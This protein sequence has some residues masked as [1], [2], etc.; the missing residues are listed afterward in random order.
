MVIDKKL[1][2]LSSLLI[3]LVMLFSICCSCKGDVADDSSATQSAVSSETTSIDDSDETESELESE[4]SSS[5]ESAVTSSNIVIDSV[6]R[7][8]IKPVS[9]TVSLYDP[10]SGIYGFNWNSEKKPQEPVVQVCEGKVFD[11]SKCKE[12]PVTVTSFSVTRTANTKAE[13]YYISKAQV[14]LKA[15][16]D[17]TYRAYDKY[18]K[19]GSEPAVFKTGNPKASS[20]TFVHI[21]DTQIATGENDTMHY[22][23][24][25]GKDFEKVLQGIKKSVS[26]AAFL[27][28]TGDIVQYSYES[29]WD[30]MI[31]NNFKLLSN[32]PIMPAA[33]NHDS[34][35][36]RGKDA[37]VKHFNINAPKQDTEKGIFYYFDYGDVRFITLNT[38]LI[39]ATG[40]LE[41]TQINWL[42]RVLE[43]NTKKWTIVSMHNPMFSVGK[44]VQHDESNEKSLAIR[45]QLYKIFAR[46]NVD[47]VLQGHD[48]TY[49]KTY[50]VL[51]DGTIDNNPDYE[52]VGSV[53]YTVNPKGV[54]YAVHGTSGN[55]SRKP[56]GDPDKNVYE[57][58]GESHD[59]SWANITVENN[60]LTVKIM[61]LEN[62]Q[63]KLWDSYGILKK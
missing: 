38:N 29:Y 30:N 57:I 21:S 54:I 11:E 42:K 60:K 55:Q 28:H 37:I 63:P 44:Y 50:P 5:A 16:T 39:S 62:G 52:M 24:G 9:L 61:Y 53:K 23:A 36:Y 17:Y 25:T 12:Y 10:E 22:A 51:Q 31:N 13:Y 41:Q 40:K 33:G 47:L 34:P 45:A 4:L 8:R 18:A 48:H 32:L 6:T 49:S 3:C 58:F 14:P 19:I 1:F 35:E 27:L 2:R 59:N 7:D 15:N 43:S 26:D 20:F 56:Y 46:Y